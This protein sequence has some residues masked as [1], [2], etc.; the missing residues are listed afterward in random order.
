M[1]KIVRSTEEAE[2]PSFA[3][4]LG[5]IEQ[6]LLSSHRVSLQFRSST[7]REKLSV[8]HID[9]V[10]LHVLLTPQD[11]GSIRQVARVDRT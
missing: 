5:V 10:H 3:E 8:T 11:S 9:A 4:L 1:R 7:E 6:S 2:E